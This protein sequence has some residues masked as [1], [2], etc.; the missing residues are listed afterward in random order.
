LGQNTLQYS[1]IQT[2]PKVI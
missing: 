1:H 2:S